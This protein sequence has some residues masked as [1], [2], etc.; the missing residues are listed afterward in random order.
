M[1]TYWEKCKEFEAFQFNPE[2]SPWPLIE[3]LRSKGDDGTIETVFNSPR[4]GSPNDPTSRQ[5]LVIHNYHERRQAGFPTRTQVVGRTDW[6]VYSIDRPDAERWTILCD[7]EFKEWFEEV[8]DVGLPAY[9]NGTEV[10]LI[11]GFAQ[12][13]TGWEPIFEPTK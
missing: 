1:G 2:E 7:S 9:S 8:E 13:S 11:T 4:P 10:G 5:R 12:S 6:V 3:W